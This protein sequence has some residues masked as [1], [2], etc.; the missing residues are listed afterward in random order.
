MAGKYEPLEIFLKSLPRDQATIS[1]SF[2]RIEEII[3]D[4]LPKSASD[5][6]PWWG[7]ERDTKSRSQA[8]AWMSAGFEV[9]SVQQSRSTGSVEF[10]RTR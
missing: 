1:L 7:N 6:R 3:G 4:T 5:Y 2:A 9:A 10:R 8:H